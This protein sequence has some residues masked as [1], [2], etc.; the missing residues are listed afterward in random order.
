MKE[1]AERIKANLAKPN[2]TVSFMDLLRVKTTF[3]RDAEAA[4]PRPTNWG[5]RFQMTVTLTAREAGR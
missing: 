1:L 4:T 5:L 2:I 3:R